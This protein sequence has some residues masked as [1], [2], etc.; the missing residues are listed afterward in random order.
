MDGMA[1]GPFRNG[2]AGQKNALI[3]HSGH[4]HSRIVNKKRALSL[5]L[6]SFFIARS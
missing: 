2:N 1:F 6:G 4:S 3:S 5:R